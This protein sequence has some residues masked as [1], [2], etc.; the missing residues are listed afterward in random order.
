M[1]FRKTIISAV[2]LFVVLCGVFIFDSLSKKDGQ[3][4]TQRGLILLAGQT[5]NE[6]NG[7]S[8]ES[9]GNSEMKAVVLPVYDAQ[10]GEAVTFMLGAE[11]PN[12]EDPEIG[13]RFGLLLNSKGAAIE[14]VIFSAGGEDNK[15]FDDRDPKNPRALELLTEVEGAMSF[16]NKQILFY[17][18]N[19]Q[20]DLQDLSWKSLGKK[21]LLYG[22]QSAS[23]EAIIR[24]KNKD[25][26][27]V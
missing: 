21:N 13:F 10:G 19:M 2:L 22:S 1:N 15:G 18:E 8:E 5:N 23:F 11:D 26:Q 12:T 25:D 24:D 7:E 20:L 9:A 3:S 14:K 17:D 6:S 27:P 4:S 16:A